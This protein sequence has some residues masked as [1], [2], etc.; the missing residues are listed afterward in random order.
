[1]LDALGIN[2]HYNPNARVRN[3]LNYEDSNWVRINVQILKDSGGDWKRIPAKIKPLSSRLETV[4]MSL[5]AL[6]EVER[7]PWGF[8]DPR[9]ALTIELLHLLLPSPQYIYIERD[10]EGVAQS[11]LSR[12]PS[13]RDKAGWIALAKVYYERIDTFLASLDDTVPVL[14]LDFEKLRSDDSEALKLAKFVA[15]PG[16]VGKAIR[17]ITK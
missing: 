10:V 5:V 12:G 11:I 2:M 13:K 14:R 6:R 16:K 4:V 3:Y 7:E 9:T 15:R 1:M 17:V 8:K